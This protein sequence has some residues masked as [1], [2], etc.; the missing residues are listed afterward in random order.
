LVALM[1]LSVPAFLF[2]GSH[3][4]CLWTYLVPIS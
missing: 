2:N 3:L 4:L 1:S